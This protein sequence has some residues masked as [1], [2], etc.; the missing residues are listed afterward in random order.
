MNLNYLLEKS[1]VVMQTDVERNYHIF[2]QLISVA[3]GSDPNLAS[4]LDLKS[5]E[6]FNITKD[7]DETTDLIELEANKADQ[8]DQVHLGQ[9]PKQ[10][11]GHYRVVSEQAQHNTANVSVDVR[12]KCQE[13]AK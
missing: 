12:E 6:L 3:N 10:P 11:R 2:Y 8:L 13:A 4:D 1:R 5:P 9:A 7:S